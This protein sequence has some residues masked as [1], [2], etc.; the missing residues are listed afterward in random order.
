MSYRNHLKPL[1]SPRGRHG[2]LKVNGPNFRLSSSGSRPDMGHCAVFFGRTPFFSQ[3][4]SLPSLQMSN[5]K[6]NT[7]GETLAAIDFHLAHM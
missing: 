1:K 7:R 6:S 4:L 5:G 2:G 3:Y